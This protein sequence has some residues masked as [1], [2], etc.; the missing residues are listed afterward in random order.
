[1]S[2]SQKYCAKL[3]CF[4]IFPFFFFFSKTKI[5]C[6]CSLP[7]ILKQKLFGGFFSWGFHNMM[8]GSLKLYW[9]LDPHFCPADDPHSLL[10]SGWNKPVPCYSCPVAVF[11]DGCVLT[12]VLPSHSLSAVQLMAGYVLWWHSFWQPCSGY[13]WHLQKHGT[14]WDR[15]PGAISSQFQYMQFLT[16][17][18]KYTVVKLWLCTVF[19]FVLLFTDIL[20]LY[21]KLMQKA[22][23]KTPRFNFTTLTFTV[24]KKKNVWSTFDMIYKFL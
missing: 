12:C 3:K 19:H 9:S 6:I 24:D 4:P 20:K 1:M 5:V 14:A 18:K 11:L 16:L 21:A 8:S 23:N 22:Q 13:I 15:Y 2:V 7:D 10:V 17:E